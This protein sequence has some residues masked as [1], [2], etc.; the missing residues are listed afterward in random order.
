MGKPLVYSET[1]RRAANAIGG[2]AN[3]ARAWRVP[4]AKVR[5]WISGA[6]PPPIERY[7]EALDLLI[8]TGAT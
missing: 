5:A 8:S 7:H 2:E 6:E 1:L 4:E 3:L